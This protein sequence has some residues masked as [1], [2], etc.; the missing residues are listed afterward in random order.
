MSIHEVHQKAKNGMMPEF[1]QQPGMEKMNC[2]YSIK[3]DGK[4]IISEGG[5][6]TYP[7]IRVIRDANSYK[8]IQRDYWMS[9]PRKYKGSKVGI[10]F[11][12]TEGPRKD[13]YDFLSASGNNFQILHRVIERKSR[14]VGVVCGI[15]KK[16]S[17]EISD[18]LEDNWNKKN[19]HKE[20]DD[21]N[22]AEF[23]EYSIKKKN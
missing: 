10:V 17:N 11:Q 16:F 19:V 6:K 5:S 13:K 3:E 22:L 8:I 18:F 21:I 12:Y 20:G 4:R 15:S 1:P 23:I 7:R 14:M 2:L 9:T